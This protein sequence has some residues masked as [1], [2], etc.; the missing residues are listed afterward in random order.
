[1]S[2]R[3]LTT[4]LLVAMLLGIGSA[5][6]QD[7]ITDTDP[8]AAA[9][10]EAELISGT[11]QLTFTGRRAGEGYYSADGSQ[12]V[13]QSEREPGNPFYQIYTIDLE[14]GDLDRVSP[15]YGK[16]T[17]AWIH[18]DGNRRDVLVHAW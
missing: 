16:T 7:D 13:F 10:R 4:F 8:L 15:G 6:G 17:C 12:M 3:Y 2:E 5:Y 1:M 18:P 14:T 9:V 11:R